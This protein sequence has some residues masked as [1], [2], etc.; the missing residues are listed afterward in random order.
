M[1]RPTPNPRFALEYALA[2]LWQAWGIQPALLIG[3][4]VG[5][6][7]AAC[8]A[9]VFTLKDGIKLVAARSRLDARCRK[10]AP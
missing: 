2:T 5:E 10:T 7:V 6:L 8:V 9:G 1:T 3:H 4:S